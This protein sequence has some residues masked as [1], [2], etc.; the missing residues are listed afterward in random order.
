MNLTPL[1][2]GLLAV[3]LGE[4]LHGYHAMGG[5]LVLFD[6]AVVQGLAPMP[7]R[8]ARATDGLRRSDT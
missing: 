7:R 3:L 6:I 2:T 1:F 5:G 8:D 4:E